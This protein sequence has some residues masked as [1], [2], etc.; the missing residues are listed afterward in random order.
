MGEIT[1]QTHEGRHGAAHQPRHGVRAPGAAGC[2]AGWPHLNRGGR[3]ESELLDRLEKWHRQAELFE[4]GGLGGH[5]GAVLGRGATDVRSGRLLPLGHRPVPTLSPRACSPRV[6]LRG[7]SA[8]CLLGS[9][10]LASLLAEPHLLEHGRGGLA[11]LLVVPVQVGL[12]HRRKLGRSGSKL[13][14]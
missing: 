9:G 3:R 10:G 8:P 5:D 12:V 6:G 14:V 13:G 1:I 4:G 7:S 2:A 11:L